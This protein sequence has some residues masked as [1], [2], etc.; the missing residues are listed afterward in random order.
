M[1]V[2]VRLFSCRRPRGW[3]RQ[4][5]TASQANIYLSYGAPLTAGTAAGNIFYLDWWPL[6]SSI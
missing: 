6:A 5:C 4:W 2:N 3:V 1:K